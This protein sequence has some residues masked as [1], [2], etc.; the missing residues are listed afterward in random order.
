MQETLNQVLSFTPERIWE[1]VRPRLFS[2]EILRDIPRS[3]TSA[4]EA[5]EILT[6]VSARLRAHGDLRAVFPDI[7]AVVT[8]RVRDAIHGPARAMFQEPQFISRLAGRFCELYLAALR[9]S[10]EGRSEPVEAWAVADRAATAAG[11]PALQHAVL[12][13]NAHIN[14]DLALGLF[15]NVLALGGGDEEMRRYRHDHDAVNQILREAL[16]EVIALLAERYRCPASRLLSDLDWLSTPLCE[17]ALGVLTMWRTRVWEDLEAL[18]D[19]PDA[20]AR[21]R[22]EARMHLRSTLLSKVFAVRSPFRAT[23]VDRARARLC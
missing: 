19:A 20:R 13:L 15:A 23:S 1:S 5:F 2:E 16:P 14:F 22:I 7:Y 3:P 8:R 6:T 4:R 18:L 11:V 17:A 10:L 9:R 12:G 21:S